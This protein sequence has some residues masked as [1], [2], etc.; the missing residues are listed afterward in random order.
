M[1]LCECR[2]EMQAQRAVEEKRMKKLLQ[3]HTLQEHALQ[4]TA[5]K[6]NNNQRVIRAKKKKNTEPRTQQRLVAAGPVHFW[7]GAPMHLAE[8]IDMGF[9]RAQAE[10]ALRQQGGSFEKALNQLLQAMAAQAP[11]PQQQR[12]GKDCGGKARNLARLPCAEP[13]PKERR[14]KKS[15]ADQQRNEEPSVSTMAPEER[16][17]TKQQQQ[18]PRKQRQQRHNKSSDQSGSARLHQH[19]Q[20]NISSAES[21]EPQSSHAKLAAEQQQH[22]EQQQPAP[23]PPAVVIQPPADWLSTGTDSGTNWQHAGPMQWTDGAAVGGYYTPSEGLSGARWG[24]TGANVIMNEVVSNG[25]ASL[26]TNAAAAAEA[27][28]ADKEEA[29]WAGEVERWVQNV[30]A[31]TSPEHQSHSWIGA[32]GIQHQWPQSASVSDALDTSNMQPVHG[33][34]PAAHLPHQKQQSWKHHSSQ[35]SWPEPM[36]QFG[37]NSSTDNLQDGDHNTWGQSQYWEPTQ[38]YYGPPLHLAFNNMALNSH[39]NPD[40]KQ[41]RTWQGSWQ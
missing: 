16:S 11:A 15:S 13:A 24:A 29:K 21:P 9:D 27:S 32:S 28:G 39:S 12:K 7:D 37:A 17:S 10:L 18:Q 22:A 41:D 33:Y 20:N 19:I 8:L 34:L 3:E 1:R 25:Q 23:L 4:L 40:I 30:A 36:S 35:A 14:I 31:L 5:E 2:E 6:A 38:Q 26:A